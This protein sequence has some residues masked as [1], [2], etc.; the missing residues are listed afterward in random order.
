MRSIQS[1]VLGLLAF[2][3]SALAQSPDDKALGIADIKALLRTPGVAQDAIVAMASDACIDFGLTQKTKQ[4]LIAAGATSSTVEALEAVCFEGAELL[5]NSDPGGAEVLIGGERAGTTPFFARFPTSFN[6]TIEVRGNGSQKSGLAELVFGQRL[7]WDVGLEA[8]TVN[9]PRRR[10]A[11]EI[12]AQLNLVERFQFDEDEPEVPPADAGTSKAI[13]T[14]LWSSAFGAVGGGYYCSRPTS[15]CGES[16]EATMNA[17]VGAAVGAVGGLA[18][19]F[20][21]S[22]F[23]EHSAEAKY[24]RARQARSN[25]ARRRIEART[26]WVNTHPELQNTLAR[27][28]SAWE[29]AIAR[30]RQIRIHNSNLRPTK[31]WYETLDN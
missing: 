20:V 12:I 17:V 15:S 13:K 25:W 19:G 10:S 28:K 26:Q 30:N 27:E 31:A 14:I 4:E 23:V 1:L 16:G 2:A 21:I 29:W 6:K 18:I 7:N 24:E 9:V 5:I 22:R 11:E 3:A 8:D